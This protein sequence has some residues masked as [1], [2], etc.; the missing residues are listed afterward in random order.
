MVPNHHGPLEQSCLQRG[1]ATGDQGQV[2]SGQRGVRLTVEQLQ[3]RHT[4]LRIDQR[5]NACQQAGDGGQ[6]KLQSRVLSLHDLGSLDKAGRQVFNFRLPA[7]GQNRHHWPVRIQPQG[8]ACCQAVRAHGNR[9]RQR[10]P[11]ISGRYARLGQQVGLEGKN[12]QHVVH[13]APNFLDALR[14]PG[15]DR[16]AHKM[17]RR[18]ACGFEPSFQIEVEIGRI[19]PNEHVGRL[20]QQTLTQLIANGDDAPVMAQHLDITPHG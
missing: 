12:A 4:A 2:T 6:D 3:T 15:P 1:R 17:H 19:H 5:L 8:L 14:A 11:H 10:V 16:G 9:L 7:A 13:A 20:G 18:N